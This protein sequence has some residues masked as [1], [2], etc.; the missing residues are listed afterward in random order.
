VHAQNRTIRQLIVQ[1]FYRMQ[2]KGS[3]AFISQQEKKEDPQQ[4]FFH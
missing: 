2:R 1:I 3:K 4:V